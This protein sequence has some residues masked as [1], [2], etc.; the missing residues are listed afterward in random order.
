M[1]I[2]IFGSTGGIGKALSYDLSHKHNIFIGSTNKNKIDKLKFD[3][4]QRNI[5]NANDY[6]AD[7]VVVDAT[8]FDSIKYFLNKANNFLGSI[9]C[10]LNCV[11]SLILKPAHATSEDELIDTFKVNVFSCF[12]ILKHSFKYMRKNGGQ[13][14][15]FSSAAYKIGLKNHEC[16]SSAK[17]AIT[18]LVSS[19]ASTYSK[20]NIRVNAIAPGLVQTPLTESITKNK[21]SL[22]Y[23]KKIHGLN[24]IG[25]PQN[26]IPIISS[27]IDERSNWITGQTF[28]I[29]GGLSNIK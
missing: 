23:S 22:E 2:V 28:K 17:G 8:D 16:I 4:N 15:F 7:G 27:L 29:D 26:L 11:G 6:L 20:Y 13:I 18:S 24:R 21:I 19:A 3:I 5:S 12:G 14:L 1:N 25:T 9:D 10:I